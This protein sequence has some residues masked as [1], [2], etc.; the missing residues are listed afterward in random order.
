MNYMQS[1]SALVAE[2]SLSG[3]MTE[4]LLRSYCLVGAHNTRSGDIAQGIVES[5]RVLSEVLNNVEHNE[6]LTNIRKLKASF[7]LGATTKNTDLC[8]SVFCCQLEGNL[9][10]TPG[11]NTATLEEKEPAPGERA[12]TLGT[13]TSLTV[14]KPP[15]KPPWGPPSMGILGAS[16]RMDDR[17]CLQHGN[18]SSLPLH[19][20]LIEPGRDVAPPGPPG[21][22]LVAAKGR[23]AVRTPAQAIYSGAQPA[24]CWRSWGLWYTP[25]P[26]THPLD[27]LPPARGYQQGPS[28]PTVR[29][30]DS[31]SGEVPARDRVAGLRCIE[32]MSNITRDCQR[33]EV[34][35]APAPGV[36][37]VPPAA[38]WGGWVATAVASQRKLDQMEESPEKIHSEVREAKVATPVA[39]PRMPGLPE[40]CQEGKE[41]HQE[42][43]T[44]VAT[45][46]AGLQMSSQTEVCPQVGD[47]RPTSEPAQ[48]SSVP[49]SPTTRYRLPRQPSIQDYKYF[50]DLLEC[51]P[52][53]LSVPSAPGSGEIELQREMGL[54]VPHAPE[55][56]GKG[57]DGVKGVPVPSAP[58]PHTTG[59]VPEPFLATLG[60]GETRMALTQAA[61]RGDA[62]D[63]AVAHPTDPAALVRPLVDCQSPVGEGWDR[64]RVANTN[65]KWKLTQQ[66]TCPTS[67]NKRPVN[68]A[69]TMMATRET[70]SCPTDR[71]NSAGHLRVPSRPLEASWLVRLSYHNPC[72]IQSE[73]QRDD[74][75]GR[76]APKIRCEKH[77]NKPCTTGVLSDSPDLRVDPEREPPPSGRPSGA[78]CRCL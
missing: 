5:V 12:F 16:F 1:Q 23:L 36:G 66:L 55:P 18:Q 45:P 29:R 57:R 7:D 77:C 34:N 63:A 53:D 15:P 39:S 17:S 52:P 42:R 43:E 20:Q 72:G 78:C 58:T 51:T 68:P 59:C 10:P 44:E 4:C 33:R 54:P 2:M 31:P 21:L 13:T 74:W 19:Q 27:L 73:I 56:L 22:P 76:F 61:P 37:E 65:P 38:A 50:L 47:D 35:P 69:E 64:P 8:G 41:A 70:N 25:W 3:R 11:P 9:A 49:G 28:R 30:Q 67:T 71:S 32:S 14:E 60:V 24:P 48:L 46:V 6:K 62:G 75:Y 26:E 40:T